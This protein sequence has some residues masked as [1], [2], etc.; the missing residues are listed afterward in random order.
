MGADL[1]TQL[2][3]DQKLLGNW[4]QEGWQGLAKGAAVKA[5]QRGGVEAVRLGADHLLNGEESDYSQRKQAYVEQGYPELAAGS[6][7]AKDLIK[8]IG[9]QAFYGGVEGA[10]VYGA[11]TASRYIQQGR[12]AKAD[13]SAAEL[14]AKAKSM[15]EGSEARRIYE[16]A[17]ARLNA[18]E[19]DVLGKMQE[20]IE[21]AAGREMTVE[22][23][24]R[25]DVLCRDKRQTEEAFTQLRK[26]GDFIPALEMGE[27]REILESPTALTGRKLDDILDQ[28]IDADFSDTRQR[29]YAKNYIN[30]KGEF[31]LDAARK[32]YRQFLESV[33]KKNNI[34]LRTVYEGTEMKRTSDKDVLF[35]YSPKRECILYNPDLPDFAA[36]N[37]KNTFTHELAHRID[38]MFQATTNNE[39]LSAAIVK[40]EEKLKPSMQQYVDYSLASDRDGFISDIFSAIGKVNEFAAGHGEAYWSKPGKR[41]K[42]IFANLFSLEAVG[43]TE[44]LTF[45]NQHFPEIMKV[46]AELSGD[47]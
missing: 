32:D 28:K 38:A 42:E 7:A 45:L 21:E 46:Y 1:L 36:L 14:V 20:A 35:G 22:N 9:A 10:M 37:M 12:Q 26:S 18:T 44:K 13:G 40:A 29:Y 16:A 31:D 15:P 33:P 43:D 23:T 6:L 34:I 39:A 17:E 11:Q 5:A 25:L 27:I 47:E 8:Q 30:E 41:E 19:R 24:D 4:T 2:P 3:V